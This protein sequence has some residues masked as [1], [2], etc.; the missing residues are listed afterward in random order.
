[1]HKQARARRAAMERWSSLLLLFLS[2]RSLFLVRAINNTKVFNYAI[3]D[4]VA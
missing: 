4:P 2:G 3:K 1:M